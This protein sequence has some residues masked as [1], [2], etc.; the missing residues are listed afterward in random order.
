MT[1]RCLTLYTRRGCPLCDEMRAALTTYVL[2]EAIQLNIVDVDT[3][4]DLKARFGWDVPLLFDEKREICR[5]EFN[6]LAFNAWLYG[7]GK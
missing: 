6:A 5:H 3:E 1:E 2:E 7:E 4:P